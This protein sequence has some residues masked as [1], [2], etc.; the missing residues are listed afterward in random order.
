[1]QRHCGFFFATPFRL[2]VGE[3]MKDCKE[4]KLNLFFTKHL[5]AFFHKENCRFVNPIPSTRER[6]PVWKKNL[7]IGGNRY[8]ASYKKE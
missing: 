5:R 7:F 3:A 8:E 2:F 6:F 4:V 1:M